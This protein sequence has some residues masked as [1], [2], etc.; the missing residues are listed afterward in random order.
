MDKRG[1]LE[2][3]NKE[4]VSDALNELLRNRAQQSINQAVEAQ[5]SKYL[6]QHQ[7]VTDNLWVCGHRLCADFFMLSVYGFGIIGRWF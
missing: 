5:L 4:S 3:N 2:F 6:S 7:P 1:I